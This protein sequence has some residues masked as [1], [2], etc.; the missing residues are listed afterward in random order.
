M[1][2]RNLH[3]ITVAMVTCAVVSCTISPS[4]YAA[5]P[6]EDPETAEEVFSAISLLQYYSDILD[7]VLKGEPAEVAAR[8]EKLPF[9]NIPQDLE[10]AISR[11]ANSSTSVSYLL[12]EIYEDLSRLGTL[13]SQ[14]RFDEATRLADQTSTKLLQINQELELV[15]EEAIKITSRW[16][17]VASAPEGSGLRK[18]Y[19]EVLE[20]TERLQEVHDLFTDILANPLQGATPADGL[21]PT[22]LT[23]KVEPVIAFV[24]DSIIF[25]GVLTCNGKALAEREVEIL[26]TGSRYLTTKTRTDGYYRGTL[27][28]PYWYIP[29]IDLQ[30]LY[31][32]RNEDI[33]HYIPSLS[34]V[35]GLE[36]LYYEAGLEVTVE[37]KAHPGLE[38]TVTG[39]FD[40]GQSPPPEER[41]VEIYLDNVLTAEVRTGE[42]FSQKI[43]LDP[44]LD[45]GS[46]IIDV[47]VVAD[48]RYSPLIASAVLDV[49]R[50]TPVLDINAPTVAMIPGSIALGGKLYSELGPL[51]GALIKAGLGKSQVELVSS[52]DGTFETEIKT[53]VGFGLIGSQDLAIQVIPQEPWH[54][55]LTTTKNMVTV[56]IVNCGSILALFVLLGIFLPSRVRFRARVYS[57]I[58]AGPAVAIT[59]PEPAPVYSESVLPP[60]LSEESSKTDGEPRIRI[61]YWY[62]LVVRL[63][64][65]TTKALL[66]PQ[67]TL[68]E[69]A[70]EASRALGPL[71]KYF[72]ELTGM[73]ERLLYSQYRA[74]E[75]DV[76]QSKQLSSNIEEGLKGEGI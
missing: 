56:N 5:E 29:E 53:G 35:T 6:H 7:F 43:K 66:K 40:Y 12:T 27:R 14:Y 39:R 20:K 1:L 22:E 23:L 18:S 36:V 44:E 50:A 62:S 38:T 46:R 67:Q 21:S 51:S 19:D 3:K 73:V 72:I 41:K 54:A 64:Q 70:R 31:Y 68:R 48:E 52:E 61:F 2:S 63:A 25:E 37:D 4:V 8:L 55:T 28:V 34:S 9:T 24:G 10:E 16:F 49:T 65:R 76:K 26:V 32:P 59:H 60:F 11:F 15:I 58:R 13:V 74:T 30:A 69:F 75:E 57:W 33:G 47:F 71:S 17:Q 45:A 42:E